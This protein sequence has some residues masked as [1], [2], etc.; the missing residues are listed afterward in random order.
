MDENNLEEYLQKEA[1]NFAKNYFADKILPLLKSFIKKH[2][3]KKEILKT[4]ESNIIEYLSETYQR[5][6]YVK[7]LAFQNVPKPLSDIYIPLTIKTEDD[8]EKIIVDD[9]IGDIESRKDFLIIDQVGM[10]KSTIARKIALEFL[11]KRKRIPIFFEFKS[12]SKN[13]N[14]FTSILDEIGIDDSHFNILEQEVDFLIILDGF[15]ETL[16]ELKERTIVEIKK[17]LKH[18]SDIPFII[19]SRPDPHL[20][21]I[22]ELQ[23]YNIVSLNEQ[24][25]YSLL[26]KY[27]N[28]GELSNK[29]ITGLQKDKT[30]SFSEFLSTPLFVSLLYCAYKYKPLLPRKK[31]LFYSQVYDALFE[32]HDL[33]KKTGYVHEK[34]S[35]LDSSDFHTIMRQFAFWCMK[36]NIKT[37]FLKDE[38]EIA[39]SKIKTN[40]HGITFEINDLIK[41]LVETVPIFIREGNK[42]RWSHKALLEY[43]SSMFICHDTKDKQKD[44]LLKMYHSKDSWAYL[45]I[46]E[47]CA[48]IDY[49]TFRAT[50]L[51]EVLE[52]LVNHGNSLIT[53]FSNKKLQE[54][55]ILERIGLTFDKE[56]ELIITKK[57]EMEKIFKKDFFEQ[58]FDNTLKF[59]KDSSMHA[60]IGIL[61]NPL[62]ILSSIGINFKILEF[63]TDKEPSLFIKN[64]RGNKKPIKI[65]LPLGKRIKIN[66]NPRSQINRKVNFTKVN[67][68]LL[69]LSELF[70]NHNEAKLLI[71]KIKE[72][73]GNDLNYL[74]NDFNLKI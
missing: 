72:D 69:S 40:L 22:H 31:H 74:L 10:G 54:K 61:E 6:A 14:L 19:T 32:S 23:R 43:F 21:E 8:K 26:K 33:S 44:I 67:Q 50:I 5:C 42:F 28:K 66:D 65:N 9:V 58:Y 7:T 24:E 56:I 59:G 38:L 20:N 2:N 15:D 60:S 16:L 64:K 73:Y 35:K 4:I 13:M 63:I 34:Y 25:A 3:S 55:V 36:E 47:L 37:E 39:F 51:K 1:L 68:I 49:T 11:Q 18:F 71:K 29:I 45:N 57:M 48:D 30:N 52:K 27:D 12:L 41:D 17:V 46:L 62:I 70:T 53:Q